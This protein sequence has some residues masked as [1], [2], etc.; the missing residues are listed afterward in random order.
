MPVTPSPSPAPSACS[1]TTAH[2]LNPLCPFVST[3]SPA[4]N[5]TST[6]ANSVFDQ[7]AQWFMS[8]LLDHIGTTVR[9]FVAVPPQ[10][11]S[12][13]AG[14]PAYYLQSHTGWLVTYAAVFGLLVAAGR[15]AW[16]RRGEAVQQ[17]F[18]GLVTL[19]L[20]VSATVA[21]VNLAVSAGDQYA[22]WILSGNT[23]V[24]L[25]ANAVGNATVDGVK[26]SLG[27]PM[28]LIIGFFGDVSVL[29]QIVLL[30][31]RGAVLVVLVALIPI[32]AAASITGGGRA[33]YRRIL[34]WLVA[35]VLYKPVVAS[36]YAVG[37]SSARG[38]QASDQ[39]EGL[40]IIILA[41]LALP[42]LLRLATPMVA[43]VGGARSSSLSG[44]AGGGVALGA[45]PIPAA[46]GTGGIVAKVSASSAAASRGP[47]GSHATPPP[48]PEKRPEKRR[49]A[50]GAK[51]LKDGEN[52]NDV[53][54]E[55]RS[56]THSQTVKGDRDG[57]S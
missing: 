28:M 34:G 14:D 11:V 52:V 22:N 57:S 46:G 25:N 31:V 8:S 1:D 33:W 13:N 15:T 5:G 4:P 43:A 56:E 27:N 18:S 39:L 30:M 35:F 20:T 29:A 51:K 16:T 19:V 12:D 41:V 38:S 36:I 26:L 54:P 47:R 17:A 42:A 55:T 6:G 44:A 49:D 2:A 50:D 3:P 32:A 48:G 7:L 45:R 21:V 37:L 23:N 53:V 40:F 24:T 10:T 9:M